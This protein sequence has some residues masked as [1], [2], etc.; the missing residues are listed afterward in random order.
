MTNVTSLKTAKVHKEPRISINK[1][2]EYLVKKAGR[3]RQILR[4]QKFPQDFMTAYYKDAQEAI[5]SFLAGNMEDIT[6]L[7][8]KKQIL[9][10]SPIKNVYSMR[11]INGNI[12]AIDNFMNMVDDIDFKGATPQLGEP[13]GKMK[14]R[15]VEVSMRPEIILTGKGAKGKQLVGG[16]KLHFNKTHPLNEEACGY[17]SAAMQIYCDNV[18]HEEGVSYSGYCIVIDIASGQVYGGVTATAQRKKDIEAACEQIASLW[19]TIG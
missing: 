4:E 14:I 17:I 16:V 6:I 11:Q 5:S 9:E 15:G 8:R 19:P 2:G 7:E 1:L 10:Q 12:E 13:S 18:L 3:Q